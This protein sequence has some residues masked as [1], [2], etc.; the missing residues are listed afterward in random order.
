LLSVTLK[1][2]LS[3]DATRARGDE[4]AREDFTLDVSF[5]APPGVTILFGASG[6]GKSLTLKA[7]AGL[8]RPDAGR[9]AVGGHVLFDSERGVDVPTA[10]RG[11]GYVFQH[12]ALL[13]HL[14]ALANVEFAVSNL[15]RRE[16]RERATELMRSLGIE[17][18]AARRPREISGGEAQRVALA[19]ALALQPKMLLLDEPLSA[20]DE[21]TK[22]S[23]IG[24]LK[25]LNSELRLPVLYV[26]HSREE[27]VALGERVVIYERGRVVA[28]GEPL[29]VFAAP[30]TA[31][32][33]RLTGVENL[34]AARVVSRNEDAGTMTVAIESAEASHAGVSAGA[35]ADANER[36]S[37]CV[38]DVPLGSRKVGDS[39]T[40]AIRSG[41]VLLATEEPRHTSARNILRGRVESVEEGH[42]RVVVRVACKGAAWSVSLTRQSARELGVAAGREVWLAIKTYSCH[43]LD[44]AG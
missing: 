6:A 26:T 42:A 19:R 15:P 12:L 28:A 35:T 31:G 36:A 41:D 32:V 25:R 14:T 37:A 44:E 22:L 17:H 38:L 40:V 34:F 11:V 2:T 1:K 13:P 10:A 43:L 27:A 8:A 29:E 39:V 33:A 24:D 16:R 5:D 18:T 20:L 4:A 21:T 23:I 7:I 9:I 3:N 30:R